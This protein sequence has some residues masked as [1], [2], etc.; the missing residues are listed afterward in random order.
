MKMK[1]IICAIMVTLMAISCFNFSSVTYAEKGDL[2]E[3]Y[4]LDIMD[5]EFE[6]VEGGTVST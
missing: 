3:G 2:G 4:D 6:A 1:K 5:K